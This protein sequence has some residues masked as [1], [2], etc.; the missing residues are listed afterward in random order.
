MKASPLNGLRAFAF[1]ADE[2]R[3]TAATLE[4]SVGPTPQSDPETTARMYLN[5]ALASRE[6]AVVS[7]E[8]KPV[9]GQAPE[10]KTLRV[11]KIPLTG[12]QTVKFRQYY[13]GI[14]VYG[15]F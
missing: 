9:D 8:A 3:A 1:H 4:A 13:R 5:Q 12:T 10:F 14:P 7:F 15:A 11:E 2:G 6:A